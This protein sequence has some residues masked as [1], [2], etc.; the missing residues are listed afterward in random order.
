[1][2]KS[3]LSRVSGVALDKGRIVAD[4]DRVRIGEAG[5]ATFAATIA[6][7]EPKYL[8]P[9]IYLQAGVSGLIVLVG[10]FFLY[11]LVG[12]SPPSVDFLVATDSEMKKV[13]W[14][15]RQVIQDSTMVVIGATFLI[16]AY[17]FISD[18]GL[19]KVMEIIGVLQR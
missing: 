8:F 16:A 2:K 19:S 13:N 4:V 10:C 17:I 1:D 6:A 18:F 7:R 9:R 5:A 14:S 15:T 12:Y 11:R 3:G